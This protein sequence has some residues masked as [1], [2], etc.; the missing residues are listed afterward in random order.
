MS[1]TAYRALFTA[2]LLAGA[3]LLSACGGDDETAATPPAVVATTAAT[4]PAATS[5]TPATSPDAATTPVD[6]TTPSKTKADDAAAS[7]TSPAAAA[8]T[9]PAA[10]T[11]TATPEPKTPVTASGEATQNKV[12][13]VLTAV[14]TCF[15][16]TETYRDCDGP[17]SLK[18]YGVKL[19]VSKRPKPGEVAVTNSSRSTFKIIGT[20]KGGVRWI[21]AKNRSGDVS[22]K[23]KLADGKRCNP[24]TW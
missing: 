23:C 21:L 9:A 8:E 17:T 5:T 20:D 13:Q 7:A 2:P 16:G 14:E 15:A 22:R 12:L 3:L 18:D 4:T 11:P 10:A 6:A 24:A 1:R 19:V